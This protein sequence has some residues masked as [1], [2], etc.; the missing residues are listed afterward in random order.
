MRIAIVYWSN[1]E[2][3]GTGTYL[4]TVLPYLRQAGHDTALFHELDAPTDH[5]P[6]DLAGHTPSWSVEQMGLEAALAAL[7]A[8]KPDL[9]YAHGLREAATEAR[10]QEVAP[11]VFFAHDYYGTCISG[12]KAFTRPTV[13]PCDR[14]FGWPCLLQYF[15]RGCGGRSPITMVREYRRQ[16]SRLELLRRYQTIVTHSTRMQQEYLRHGMRATRVFEVSAG[17]RAHGIE[18]VSMAPPSQPGDPWRLLFLGR[19]YTL[20]GGR[21]LIQA[22][23]EVARRLAQPV[24]L[25]LAGE[26]PQRDEWQRLAR[27]V[28]A[29]HASVRIE[30]LAWVDRDGVDRLLAHTHL[31][32]TPSLWPEPYGLVGIE[33]GRHGVPVAAYAVGGIPDWLHHGVNG[34]LAPGDPPSVEGLSQAITSCLKDPARYLELRHGASQLG[35]VDVFGQHGEALLGVFEEAMRRAVPAG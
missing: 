16:S 4:G 6:L 1:R 35:A 31:L 20:K 32:V 7:R 3:G 14:T 23:P 25:T 8:W 11:A 2:V 19:M 27:D 29:S 5:T 13:R 9:I 33:A 18:P 10:V 30:F 22:L 24:H 21:E 28:M 17:S 34:Y 26:G 12:G 15:P